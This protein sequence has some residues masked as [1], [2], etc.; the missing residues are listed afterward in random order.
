MTRRL[1]FVPLLVNILLLPLRPLPAQQRGSGTILA[2][3]TVVADRL[4]AVAVRRFAFE[5]R[6]SVHAATVDPTDS[7]AA[8]WALVGQANTQVQIN[9]TLPSEVVNLQSPQAPGLPVAFSRGAGRWRQEVNDPDDAASFDPR[10]GTAVRFR[11]GTAP[12]V[13]IWL[14]GTVSPTASTAPGTYQGTV[15]LTLF[16]Y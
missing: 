9:F 12:T 14:G 11:D 2:S 7:T 16:Y 5:S 6:H 3:A 13:Y 15:T 4:S 1:G 8:Q 10:H